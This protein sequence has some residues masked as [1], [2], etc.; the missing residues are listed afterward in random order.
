MTMGPMVRAKG[1]ELPKAPVP[2]RVAVRRTA[3][4]MPLTVTLPVQA[5]LL[6]A[7]VAVGVMV[8]AA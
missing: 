4:P 6:K 1:F 5:P 8:T 3:S 2:V 7:V